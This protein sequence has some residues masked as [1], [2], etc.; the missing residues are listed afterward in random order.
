MLLWVVVVEL[1]AVSAIGGRIAV[2]QPFLDLFRST[3]STGSDDFGTPNVVTA[4]VFP[5][6]L[7]VTLLAA[8][9]S[10]NRLG[11]PPARP[12]NRRRPTIRRRRT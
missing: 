4:L 7:A 3:F 2:I 8:R 10:L 11:F 1:V 5:L 9:L 6:Y 12:P